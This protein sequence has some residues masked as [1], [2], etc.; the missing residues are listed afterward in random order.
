MRGWRMLKRVSR[1]RSLV[2]RVAV[3]RGAW[4]WRER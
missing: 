4:S 3:P 1:R 2:G